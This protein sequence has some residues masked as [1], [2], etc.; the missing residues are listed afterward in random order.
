MG[1]TV[2]VIGSSVIDLFLE[3]KDPGKFAIA[4]PTVAFKLGDKIP[5]DIKR[6]ALGGNG[7]N[8][9][10]GLKRLGI[11]SIFYTYF[12]D[13]LFSK[14]MEENLKK[15]AID[16]IATHYPNQKG[17]ISFVLHAGSDRIIFSHHETHDHRFSFPREILPDFIYLTSTGETWEKAYQEIFEFANKNSLPVFFSPGSSQLEHKT[18][19]VN[20]IL[21]SSYGIFVNKEEAEKLLEWENLGRN[22]MNEIL[23]SLKSFGIKI[24]SVTDGL[25]GA[26]AQGPDG[27]Y[28][29]DAPGKAAPVVEK[30]GA[31]DAYASGFLA[32]FIKGGKTPVCMK[33]GALNAFSV[34]QKI[35]AQEGLLNKRQ[36]ENFLSEKTK[37]EAVNM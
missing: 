35:G 21:H 27:N 6:I 9:S 14:E 2:L 15:E 36:M 32:G 1:K 8:V 13:D 29:I 34:M 33:S 4:G 28:K 19:I 16:L 23:T 30:T 22:S 11:N 26:F 5:T 3:I 25:N 17:S 24:I 37:I 7:A 31:G 10:V 12:G 18:D 20:K